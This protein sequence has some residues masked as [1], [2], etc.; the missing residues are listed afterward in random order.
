M[1]RLRAIK[2]LEGRRQG[3]ADSGPDDE[4]GEIILIRGRAVDDDKLGALTLRQY[5]EPRC[6]IDHQRGASDQEEI[7]GK[8]GLLRAQHLIFGHWLPE[9]NGR[10]LDEPAAEAAVRN[11]AILFEAHAQRRDLV[12]GAAS[13]TFGISGIAVQ[14]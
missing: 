14:L 2:K 8:S 12:P 13:E 6:R 5:G 7:A 3:G 10:R 1:R 4:I 9:R 11:R